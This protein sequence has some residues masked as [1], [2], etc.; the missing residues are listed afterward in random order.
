MDRP[1]RRWELA[2]AGESRGDEPAFLRIARAITA[3]IRRGRLRSGALLPGTRTLARALAVHRN[4]VVAAYEELAAEGWTEGA[5][6]RG[7]FVSRALPEVSDRGRP[8]SARAGFDLP[9]APPALDAPPPRGALVL[10]AGIPD[11]RLL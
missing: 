6:G 1:L 10:A 9:P 2:W 5:P 11:V 8:V 3:D 4:T 7:T